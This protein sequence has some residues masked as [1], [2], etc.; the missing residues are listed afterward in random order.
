MH[1]SSESRLNIN[2][3]RPI[4]GEAK[5][6][7]NSESQNRK[8]TCQKTIGPAQNKWAAFI[9]FVPKRNG[10]LLFCVNYCKL[11]VVTKRKL[12]QIPPMDRCIDSLSTATIFS[13]LYDIS[14]NS[15]NQNW[16]NYEK[17]PTFTLRHGLH[18]LIRIPFRLCNAPGT[19]QRIIDV[20]LSS[21]Y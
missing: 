17:K 14:G 5:E 16:N 3:I 21:V 18:R 10:T 7:K 4:S 2:T 11:I 12:Y 15:Q 8:D 19:F 1:H 13:T 20:I 6:S 9:E